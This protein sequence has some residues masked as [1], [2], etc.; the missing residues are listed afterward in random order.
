M[1]QNIR[2]HMKKVSSYSQAVN[3]WQWVIPQQFNMG[4]CICDAQDQSAIALIVPQKNRTQFEYTFGDLR[5]ESN[6]LINLLLAY[7]VSQ[8]D[9]VAILLPQKA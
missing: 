1:Q 9:R 6:K 5:K 7:G 8:G 2:F 3:E 4:V